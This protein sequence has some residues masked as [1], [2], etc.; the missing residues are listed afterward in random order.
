MSTAHECPFCYAALV[1]CDE[2]HFL[3]FDGWKK[4]E[5]KTIYVLYCRKCK[6]T[7]HLDCMEVRHV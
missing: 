5:E 2:S 1:E 7:F 6:E 3:S 4:G